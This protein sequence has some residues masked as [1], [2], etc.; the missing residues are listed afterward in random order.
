L[1]PISYLKFLVPTA[2]PVPA[3]ERADDIIHIADKL[4]AELFIL[5]I[6]TPEN[7]GNVI[8][9]QEGFKAL[10]IFKNTAEN[11]NIKITEILH[12]GEIVPSITQF[13]EEHN[14]DL[15]IMGGGEDCIV[16][17]WII[18][19]LKEQTLVPVVV[20]PVGFSTIL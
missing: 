19:D 14:I 1:K 16:A 18:S 6:I 5:H 11:K 12:E 10:E 17:E 9:K 15:I 20:I 3:R 7:S 8:K 13:A 2:G 4:N